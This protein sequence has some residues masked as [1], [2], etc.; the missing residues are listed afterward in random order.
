[1]F[2]PELTVFIHEYLT[3]TTLKL[4]VINPDAAMKYVFVVV[5]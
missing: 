4:T 1:M 5:L 3:Y 2:S